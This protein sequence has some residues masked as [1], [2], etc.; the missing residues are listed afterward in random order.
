MEVLYGV[1]A[2]PWGRTGFDGDCDVKVAGRG[3]RGLVKNAK[4][5]IIANDYDYAL[6]A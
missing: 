1:S 5:N 2:H 3:S 4:K 6:A